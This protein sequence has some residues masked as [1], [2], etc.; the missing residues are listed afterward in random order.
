METWATVFIAGDLPFQVEEVCSKRWHPS[1]IGWVEAI[2]FILEDMPQ[3]NIK[4]EA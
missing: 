1:I 4:T 2:L 3:V